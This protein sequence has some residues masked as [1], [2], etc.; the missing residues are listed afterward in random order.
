M[1]ASNNNSTPLVALRP[2]SNANRDWVAVMLDSETEADLASVFATP[3]FLAAIAPLDC[4]LPL[5]QP[6]ADSSMLAALPADRILFNLPAAVLAQAEPHQAVLGYHEAGYRV[7]IDGPLPDGVPLPAALRAVSRDLGTDEAMP[8]L[9]MGGPHLARNVASIERL[10]HCAAAGS[11][12]FAG[13][14]ALHPIARNDGQDDGTSRKRLLS[15][16]GLLARDA[17]SR[18]IENLL[19]QD[20]ALSYHLLKLANSAA[21]A[22]TT[23]IHSFGQAI[24]VLGRRQLQRWLQLLLYARPQQ[25][26]PHNPLLPLA[27]LRGGQ[28]E[29]L[30]KH[31]GGDKEEQDLAFMTGVFSLLDLLLGMTMD[32]IVASLSLPSEAAQALLT[33]EGKLGRWLALAEGVPS[34]ALLDR[35]GVTREAC[36]H[37]QLHAFHWAIQVS[38]NL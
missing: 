38:R 3:D 20:P 11:H 28:L 24:N 8:L 29:Y 15:L 4:L 26:G 2:V 10:E 31:S 18:D 30:C 32:E 36:W 12:W 35:A 21:F 33:R 37:S 25:S 27:A 13:E 5:S 19:K 22:V 6:L 14:F 23:P 17:D 9:P 34:E 16:L 7:Q 1:A